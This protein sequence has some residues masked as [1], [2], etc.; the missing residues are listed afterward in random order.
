MFASYRYLL[1]FMEVSTMVVTIIILGLIGIML[2]VMGYMLWKKQRITLLHE[3]HYNK[4][5]EKDKKAFCTISGIGV[6]FIGIGLLITGIVISFTDAAWSFIFFGIGF[7][8]GLAM[9]IYAGMK[10]NH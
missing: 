7:L 6:L 2:V 4:V 3:Y 5:S 10:Y 9:L 8:V 1:Y